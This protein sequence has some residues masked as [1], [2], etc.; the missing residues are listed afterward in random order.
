MTHLYFAVSLY[1]NLRSF[2]TNELNTSF[3]AYRRQVF[4]SPFSR[5]MSMRLFPIFIHFVLFFKINFAGQRN[6]DPPFFAN[7]LRLTGKRSLNYAIRLSRTSFPHFSADLFGRYH[8]HRITIDRLNEIRSLATNERHR[9][10]ADRLRSIRRIWCIWSVRLSLS[11]IADEMKREKKQKLSFIRKKN[12]K[13]LLTLKTHSSSLPYVNTKREKRTL[14]VL[15]TV[16]AFN[17]HQ[18]NRSASSHWILI[19]SDCFISVFIVISSSLLVKVWVRMMRSPVVNPNHSTITTIIRGNSKILG[20][21]NSAI[22]RN[23]AMK[24]A[25]AFGAFPVS[26]AT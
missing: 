18:R 7:R 6:T 25:T 4:L 3:S 2:D 22:V 5:A 14:F 17:R 8:L 23:N 21:I 13:R 10:W 1:R 9:W 16:Q 20:H 11:L 26:R 24:R 15:A 19:F 12:V